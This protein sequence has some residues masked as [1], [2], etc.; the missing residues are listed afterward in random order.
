MLAELHGAAADKQPLLEEKIWNT[1]GVEKSVFVLDMSRYSS[2][3][4]IHGVFH[5]LWMIQRMRTAAAPVINAHKGEI[6]E[7]KADNFLVLFDAPVD[8]VNAAVALNAVFDQMNLAAPDEDDIYIKVG[9][10]YGKFLRVDDFG[11]FGLPINL[12][13]KLGED[14][15]E[16]SEI[17]ISDTV[18]RM[19]AEDLKWPVQQMDL[20]ISGLQLRVYRVKF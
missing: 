4:Y 8:A 3:I 1:F 18:Y 11:F 2:T 9:I 7:Q 14:L 13:S 12:A 16:R 17:L 15:A 20:A 6:L 19:C 10:D 5:S